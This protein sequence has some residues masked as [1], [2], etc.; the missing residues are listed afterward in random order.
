MAFQTTTASRD[1]A[2]M[3]ITPLVDVMLV[4]L[5]IFMVAAPLL[6]RP[7]TL[8]LPSVTPVPP[9]P[10]PSTVTLPIDAGGGLYWNG[11]PMSQVAV[12]AM[13][14]IE[15]ARAEPPL[16]AIEI[17]DEADYAHVAAALGRARQAGIARIGLP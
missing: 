15:G 13:L 11:T 1:I 4:L 16:L 3:N 6:S 2:E 12:D 14:R 17:A 9:P 7:L 8:D 5:I 10:P